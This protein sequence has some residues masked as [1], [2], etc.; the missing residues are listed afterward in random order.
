MCARQL[1]CFVE[2][3]IPEFFAKI[4]VLL[5]RI[6][7][8]TGSKISW[9]Q[10][11][12]WCM[13]ECALYIDLMANLPCSSSMLL[14]PLPTSPNA[15]RHAIFWRFSS[16]GLWE[17]DQPDPLLLRVFSLLF[18]ILSSSFFHIYRIPKIK[19]TASM[20]TSSGALMVSWC[21]V[22]LC[23]SLSLLSV[24]HSNY[25]LCMRPSRL[26]WILNSSH[27]YNLSLSFTAQQFAEWQR[28]RAHRKPLF[29]K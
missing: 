10:A 16:W 1:L 19:V 24:R 6:L 4:S 28:M 3:A 5:Q 8:R 17:F 29:S 23:T 12:S 25:S 21:L 9:E 14:N 2:P 11:P 22:Q 27:N 26:C 7:Y 20:A 15:G 13:V 18:Y